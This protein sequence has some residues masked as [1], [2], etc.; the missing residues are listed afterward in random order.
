MGRS[1]IKLRIVLNRDLG[2]VML[3]EIDR[4][5]RFEG[6]RVMGLGSKKIKAKP[7]SGRVGRGRRI[8]KKSKGGL[9]WP[10]L[11]LGD[12]VDLIAPGFG[13]SPSEIRGAVRFLKSWGLS[14]RVPKDL[15]GTD[16]LCSNSD[17]RRF[18]FLQ[19]ALLAADSKAIW[20]LRGGYGA[21]RLLPFLDELKIPAQNKVLLGYSDVTSLHL[22][23][24]HQWGWNTIHGPLLDRFSKG[25]GRSRDQ[26]EIRDCLFAKRTSFTSKSFVP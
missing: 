12:V 1:G 15:L 7:G 22:F 25:V 20:C 8:A 17:V 24:N 16:V 2:V 5:S 4:S 26:K 11:D 18:R 9:S 10:T 14:P 13:S 3:E 21:N 23:L 19:R 6:N